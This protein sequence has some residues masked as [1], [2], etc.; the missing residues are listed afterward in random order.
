MRNSLG[1]LSDLAIVVADAAGGLFGSGG[2]Y[3]GCIQDAVGNFAKKGLT[4]WSRDV[5]VAL[6]MILLTRRSTPK[7]VVS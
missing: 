1:T 3:A 2:I 7:Y 5:F 4:F 6:F